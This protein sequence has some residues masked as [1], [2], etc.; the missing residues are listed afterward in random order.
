MIEK[1]I[2]KQ[3]TKYNMTQEYLASELSISRPTYIQIEHGKRELTVTEAKK[4][5]LIFN[6]TLDDFLAGRETKNKVTLPGQVAKK[7]DSLQI[8]ITEKNLEKFKQVLLYVLGKVGSKPNVGETV[9]HKLLYFIDFDYYEKFEENL[10]GA[11][12]IKNHHGPTSAELGSIIED[13][14][15]NGELEAVKSNYFKYEQ[16]KYLPRK[17]PN[18][19]V[20]SAREIEHIDDVLARLSDKNAR[21]IENYSH[22][23]IPWKSAQDGGQLSYESVFYRDEGYS[24]RNYDDEL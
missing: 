9:L 16:K 13:M 15:K 22:G 14:Q 21:E 10:M 20:L 17:R 6:M 8:R 5:A 18:L 23:D 1:F 3:R 12:Y 4:L 7:Q 2:Q 24:V 11:T 19:D